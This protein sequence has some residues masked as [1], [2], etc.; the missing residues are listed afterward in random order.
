MEGF[1]CL[2]KIYPAG[3]DRPVLEDVAH[4]TIEDGKIIVETLFGERQ[5]FENAIQTISFTESKVRLVKPAG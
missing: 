3:A 1:M 5:V 4:I 2:A